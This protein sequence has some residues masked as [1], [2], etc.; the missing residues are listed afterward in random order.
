M[1]FNLSCSI[2]EKGKGRGVRGSDF[3][4]TD[5]KAISITLDIKFL[6]KSITGIFISK[7]ILYREPT[8]SDNCS[9]SYLYFEKKVKSR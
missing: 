8:I 5:Y 9:Y 3:N 4:K 7:I 6:R 2:K 1:L